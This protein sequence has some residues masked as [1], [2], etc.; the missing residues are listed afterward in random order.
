MTDKLEKGWYWVTFEFEPLS[1][2]A[3]FLPTIRGDWWLRAGLSEYRHTP[4][5]IGPRLTPPEGE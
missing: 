4:A 1:E 3:Y 5:I 2:P